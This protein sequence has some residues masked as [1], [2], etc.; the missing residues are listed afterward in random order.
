[1]NGNTSP[2]A[3]YPNRASQPFRVNYRQKEIAT[4]CGNDLP[5]FYIYNVADDAPESC[6]LYDANTDVKVADLSCSPHLLTHTT[7]ID[8]HSVKMWIYQGTQSGIFG[9][10]SKGYYYLKIGSYYSDIF[11]I[12]DLPAEYVKLEWQ[13]YDD[14]ITTD[15]SLISKYV[16]YKQIFNVPLWHPEYSIEEEG[17]NNNGIYYAMQQTTKK[18]SGFSTIVNEAQC[19]VLSLIAPIA[20]SI[21]I[22]SCLNGQIREMRTNRF[23]ITSKWQSDDV[24]HIECEFDLL[25]IIRKYQKS[26][27]APDPLPIPTPPPPVTDYV[28]RGTAQSGVNAI[29]TTIAGS[30][31]SIPVYSGAWTYSYNTPLTGICAFDDDNITSIDLSRSCG[32]GSI[33]GI[34]FNGARI[35]SIDFSRVTFAALTKTESMFENATSIQSISMPDALLGA[36]TGSSANMFR[37]CSSLKTISIPTNIP[38]NDFSYFF[39]GC[40]NLNSVSMANQTFT[41]ATNF[42]YMFYSAKVSATFSF[43]ATATLAN[44]TSIDAMFA[45]SFGNINVKNIF[46]N[47]AIK[48]STIYGIGTTGFCDGARATTIDLDGVDF[49]LVTNFSRMFLGCANLTT[50]NNLDETQLNTGTNFTEAFSSTPN[51][52]IGSILANCTFAECVTAHGLFTNGGTNIVLPNA[53]FAKLQN[54]RMLFYGCKATNIELPVATFGVFASSDISNWFGECSQ[55]TTIKMQSATFASLPRRTS[56]YEWFY[57]ERGQHYTASTTITTFVGSGC[58]AFDETLTAGSKVL[59]AQSL[60]EVVGMVKSGAWLYILNDCWNALSAADQQSVQTAANNLGVVLK[61]TNI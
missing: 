13:V 60:I 12:G 32:L 44:A 52:N 5:P 16:V 27:V 40:Q 14:I 17:K 49:S 48:P 26:D 42:A 33:T 18:T 25:T 31:V 37:N 15:G 45:H 30:S 51:I 28:I 10:S 9:N 1:M 50:I 21:K 56:G 29:S 46:P 53:T 7:T 8:G 19:D 4:I 34:T 55:L 3:F 58:Q 57:L 39:A 59:T 22:T 36:A 35:A 38:G 24:T 11:K 6:E 20:D 41:N 47:A 43:A 54:G 61:F 2:I 23:E